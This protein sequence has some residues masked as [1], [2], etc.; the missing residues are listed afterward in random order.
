MFDSLR[1]NISEAPG[2]DQLGLKG[3]PYYIETLKPET[4]RVAPAG[5][6]SLGYPYSISMTIDCQLE[7][8][9]TVL[10][11]DLDARFYLCDPE[12]GHLA[13]ERDGYLIRFDYVMPT[14]GRIRLTIEGDN[15]STR[16]FVDGKLQQELRRHWVETEDTKARMAWV[17]TLRFPLLQSGEFRST[18][19][20]VTIH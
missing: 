17:P 16:L 20:N 15:E 3:R 1:T 7:E 4:E 2:V 12:E 10:T 8:L 19:T 13:F 18:I 9:G 11:E 14:E 6:T 5:P